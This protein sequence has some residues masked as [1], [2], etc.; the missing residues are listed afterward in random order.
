MNLAKFIK[1]TV[2]LTSLALVYIHL[3]MQIVDLAYQ[4]QKREKRIEELVEKNG[5]A[6][7]AISK[8]T[9][10]NHLGKELLAKNSDMQFAGPK[11]IMQ[12]AAPAELSS[13]IRLSRASE[14]KRKT[15]ALL[16]LLSFEGQAEAKNRE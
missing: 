7:Y 14:P 13:G 2:L 9:S 1:Y 3:Q 5:N 15:T 4:G 16:G 10:A 11:D 6:F 8:L 12:M